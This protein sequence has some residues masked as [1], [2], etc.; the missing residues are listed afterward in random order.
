LTKVQ[1][2]TNL[3][4]LIEGLNVLNVDGQT[5]VAVQG[6]AYDSRKVKK[7]FIFVAVEGYKFDGHDYI[8][9]AVSNGASAVVVQKQLTE[10]MGCIVVRVQN[11]RYALAH[12]ADRFFGHPS[13]MLNLIGVTGTKGKTTTTY[14]IRSILRYTGQRVGV[15]GTISN[16]IGDEVLPAERTTPESYDLQE[17]FCE[18]IQKEVDTAV[19]EVSS[20]ALDLHRV[21]LC[22][23]KSKIIPSTSFI[24][25]SRQT[26]IIFSKLV[27]A[28]TYLACPFK[29]LSLFPDASKAC[30][31]LSIPI[32]LPC[33]PSLL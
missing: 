15:I 27:L 4:E 21:S 26:S 6:I 28:R 8:A 18:M 9:A 32:S 33:S 7:G 3:K 24:L 11:T 31:S 20:H 22:D 23:F 19:I 25:F 12:L 10:D 5:N 14:M 2:S 17:L 1:I 29:D 13:K 30:I 16:M